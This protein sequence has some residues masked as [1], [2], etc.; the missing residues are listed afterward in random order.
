MTNDSGSAYLTP[1]QDD[2]EGDDGG[3]QPNPHQP[4]EHETDQAQAV[5]ERRV[6]KPTTEVLMSST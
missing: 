5:P 3:Q 1:G 6:R 2:G 4:E